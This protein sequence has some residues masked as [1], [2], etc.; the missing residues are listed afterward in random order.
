MAIDIPAGPD[1]AAM[2]EEYLEEDVV[3]VKWVAGET[4]PGDRPVV[5][6]TP[7][8]KRNE[9][10]RKKS[11]PVRI[12]T[13]KSGSSPVFEFLSRS[14]GGGGDADGDAEGEMIPPHVIVER[15]FGGSGRRTAFSVCTGYGRTLKGRDLRRVRNSVL[16]QTGFLEGRLTS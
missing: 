8:A 15:R 4:A 16:M 12:P 3:L 6:R 10:T 11:S 2:A 7:A 14:E 5:G 13:V 9:S 1:Q